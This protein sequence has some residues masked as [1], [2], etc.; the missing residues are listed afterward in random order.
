MIGNQNILNSLVLDHEN[1][2]VKDSIGD[3]SAMDII[4]MITHEYW[5]E[6]RHQMT[7]SDKYVVFAPG[8]GQFQLRYGRTKMYLRKLIRKIRG[9]RSK[10][11]DTYLIEGTKGYSIHA[12]LIKKFRTTWEQ[13]DKLKKDVNYKY[14]LWRQRKID[15]YGDKAIL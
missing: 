13:V 8:L 6:W 4:N 12:G 9:V 3:S 5:K 1:N 7:N 10:Y 11:E 14:A 2:P 15:Y